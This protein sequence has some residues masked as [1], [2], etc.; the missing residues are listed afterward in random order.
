L[1]GARDLFLVVSSPIEAGKPFGVVGSGKFGVF[2]RGTSY[3][4]LLAQ[5]FRSSKKICAAAATGTADRPL[6][7]ARAPSLPMFPF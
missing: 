4:C 7:D 2:D 3:I 5:A 1:R 6:I